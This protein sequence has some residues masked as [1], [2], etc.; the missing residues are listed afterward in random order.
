MYMRDGMEFDLDVLETTKGN[1][2][3]E[4]REVKVGEGHKNGLIRGQP[5]CM[6]VKLGVLCFGGPSL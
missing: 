6:V 1:D 5:H 4:A 3:D 2:R